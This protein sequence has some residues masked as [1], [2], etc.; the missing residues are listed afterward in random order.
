MAKNMPLP[1]VA[2]IAAAA[3][4]LIVLA[5]MVAQIRATMG[6]GNDAL[7]AAWAMLRFFTVLSNLLLGIVMLMEAAGRRVSAFVHGGVAMAMI[8]VG[9]VY[10]TLLRG[11]IEL[12]GGAALADLLFH[13]VAPLCA[14][15]WW[16][17]FAPKGG[18]KRS[19]PLWFALYP[20][21]YLVYALARAQ[22][23]GRYPYPFIN[24]AELGWGAVLLNSA[25][26]AAGFLVCGYAMVWLDRRLGVR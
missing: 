18:L 21:A 14:A 25:L 23:D 2:R 15:L 22:V 17:F 7:E 6:M 4:A 12:S 16:L 10:M 1:A 5:A 19:A 3:I 8:L 26:M 20:V 24:V 9:I 11:L 13:K